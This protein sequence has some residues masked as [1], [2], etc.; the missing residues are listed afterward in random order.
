MAEVHIVGSLVG[1][2][3]FEQGSLFCKWQLITDDGRP[4]NKRYLACGA[5][6]CAVRPRPRRGARRR[7]A[8]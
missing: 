7:R 3:D 1:G 2:K 5:H 8:A 6:A 4:D